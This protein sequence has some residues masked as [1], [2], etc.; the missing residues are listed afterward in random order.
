MAPTVA[1]CTESEEE[2]DRI[3]LLLLRNTGVANMLDGCAASL[4]CHVAGEAPVGL[5]VAGLAG[6][7]R[8]ILAVAQ[9]VEAVLQQAR[10]QPSLS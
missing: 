4:P 1:E 7:D 3:N 6:S 9:G 5:S 2:Y 10:L 8:H